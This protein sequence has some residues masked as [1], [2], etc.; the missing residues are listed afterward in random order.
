[1][2]VLTLVA[3]RMSAWDDPMNR[4]ATLKHRREAYIVNEELKAYDM[5]GALMKPSDYESV[6]KAGVVAVLDAKPRV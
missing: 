2:G 6:F 4:Y 1:M 5:T 3:V